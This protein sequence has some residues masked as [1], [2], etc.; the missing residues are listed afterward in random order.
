MFSGI[1]QGDLKMAIRKSPWSKISILKFAQ[2]IKKEM[3]NACFVCADVNCSLA[4]RFKNGTIKHFDSEYELC[5]LSFKISFYYCFNFF[6]I[7][8]CLSPLAFGF[9]WYYVILFIKLY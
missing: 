4:I 5:S 1:D 6:I 3:D 9:L 2:G 8:R 7:L